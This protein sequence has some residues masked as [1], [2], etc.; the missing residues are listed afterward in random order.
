MTTERSKTNQET[1]IRK[2]IDDRAVALRAKNAAGVVRHHAPEFVH[3]SLAPPL[4]STGAD[5]KG[6]EAW[7]STWQGP[8]GYEM[9]GLDI[10]AADD[11]AFCHGLTRLSGTKRDGER[12]DIWFRHTLCLRRIEGEWKITHE[13]ESVPFYMDGSLRAAVDLTP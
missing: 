10:T 8:I 7:F 13:H 4:I 11:V 6:L 9:R 3:F 12:N 5:A 2:V 1:H